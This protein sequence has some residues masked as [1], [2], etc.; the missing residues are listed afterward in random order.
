M[1]PLT[2]FEIEDL[3]LSYSEDTQL[4]YGGSRADPT[5]TEKAFYAFWRN[6]VSEKLIHL[7][8]AS[9]LLYQTLSM[10][11]KY[12][13]KMIDHID[14]LPKSQ[15][16]AGL[17]NSFQEMQNAILL[18]QQAATIGMDKVSEMIEAEAKQ[19]GASK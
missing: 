17:Q 7:L 1:K 14:M 6:E 13:Q 3:V 5:N 18:A 2:H 10:Q 15:Q 16:L 9:P 12:L 8:T 4:A 19:K 11:F